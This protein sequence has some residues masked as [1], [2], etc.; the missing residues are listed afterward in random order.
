MKKIKFNLLQAALTILL[1]VIFLTN[2]N[3]INRSGQNI[4][5]YCLPTI[6]TIQEIETKFLEYHVLEMQ[7]RGT[8]NASSVDEL[9]TELAAS[10]V[11]FSE[12]EQ[13]ETVKSLWEQS[14]QSGSDKPTEYYGQFLE[15]IQELQQITQLRMDMAVEE[16]NASYK[17]A[18]V[19][20]VM[21][22]IVTAVLVLGIGI[23][24]NREKQKA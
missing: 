20:S 15:K 13:I 9:F 8:G 17:I 24:T 14:I 4:V 5:T 7:N 6:L 19:M 10:T 12:L 18:F 2:M 16:S 1:G 3:A 11:N 21:V 23:A 22:M